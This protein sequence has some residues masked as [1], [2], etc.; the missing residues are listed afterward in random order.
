MKEIKIL[1][2]GCCS[3]C[4]KAAEMIKKVAAE[5]NFQ[6]TI[7]KVDDMMEIIKYGVMSTPAVIIDGKIAFAGGVPTKE[8]AESWF[9]EG[10]C[11]GGGCCN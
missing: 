1:G 8:Q 9:K 5:H 3:K 11:C 10:C 7:E 4:E 2:T 6:G